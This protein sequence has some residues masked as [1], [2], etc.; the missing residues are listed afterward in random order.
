VEKR[1]LEHVVQA[2]GGGEAKGRIDGIQK[3]FLLVR[4]RKDCGD[5][6][7]HGGEHEELPISSAKH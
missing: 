4:P 7:G 6:N 1:K 3:S 5:P 2:Q